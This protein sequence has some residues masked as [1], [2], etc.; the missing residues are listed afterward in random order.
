MKRVKSFWRKDT[1]SNLKVGNG[2]EKRVFGIPLNPR[3]P[4]IPDIVKS[5]TTYIEEFAIQEAGLFRVSG[6]HQE[7]N[8]LK[9]AYDR[10]EKIDFSLISNPHAVSSVLKQYLR[11]LPEPLLAFN[12][13]EA[14]ITSY[15]ITDPEMRLA[16]IKNVIQDLPRHYYVVLDCLIAFLY[17]VSLYS[18]YNKM[19][20]SNLAICFAP[21]LLRSKSE[22]TEQLVSD[23]HKSTA[24]VKIII[25]QYSEIFEKDPIT[26]DS[27]QVQPLKQFISD[28]YLLPSKYHSIN[29]DK[30]IAEIFEEEI[31]LSEQLLQPQLHQKHHHTHHDRPSVFQI[32]SNTPSPTSP[33]S[34]NSST[35]SHNLPDLSSPD[36]HLSSPQQ[37]SNHNHLD[38]LDDLSLDPHQ[39]NTHEH[40]DIDNDEEEDEELFKC[41]SISI[42]TEQARNGQLT[43][44]EGLN[45]SAQ[46]EISNSN[47]SI[48]SSGGTS[49]NKRKSASGNDV[50]IQG[51]KK[52]IDSTINR[53]R[54]EFVQI[55]NDVESEAVSF[56]E[57]LL[58]A[59]TMKNIMNI[60]IEGPDVDQKVVSSFEIPLDQT[61]T[62]G[63][64]QA[65]RL[66]T[67][68][69]AVVTRVT[70]SIPHLLQEISD[71]GDNII[72][73]PD[74]EREICLIDL[75]TIM[76]TLRAVSD[77][78][79]FFYNKWNQ[80]SPTSSPMISSP[81]P[82]S[83]PV[84]PTTITTNLSPSQN[85]SN[86]TSTQ[87]LP[88]QSPL[89]IS[90]SIS[91]SSSTSSNTTSTPI[92]ILVSHPSKSNL[93][94][95]LS[96]P[97]SFSNSS[98]L[99][100]ISSNTNNIGKS[101][102]S[103]S[104]STAASSSL[105]MS[106]KV[107]SE[108]D[109]IQR[110]VTIDEILIES[111]ES[112][113][114]VNSKSEL[115]FLAKVITNV[116]KIIH[117]PLE[118]A[119]TF[120]DIPSPKI[121][122]LKST[123]KQKLAPLISVVYVLIK[124]IRDL[125]QISKMEFESTTASKLPQKVIQLHSQRFQDLFRLLS[126]LPAFQTYKQSQ[127]QRE[128]AVQR[129]CEFMKESIQTTL[130][131]LKPLFKQQKQMVN[132]PVFAS[133]TAKLDQLLKLTRNITRIKKLFEDPQVVQLT[134]INF[135]SI[136]N[137]TNSPKS[138]SLSISS[139]LRTKTSQ[140]LTLNPQQP[141]PQPQQQQQQPQQQPQQQEI[142]EK[143]DTVKSL[144]SMLI[145]NVLAKMDYLDDIYFSVK[146]E[147][148]LFEII[149]L[150]KN[151]ILIFKEIK[152]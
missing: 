49:P 57:I 30:E 129:N 67:L 39:G 121:N 80:I 130:S 132:E 26:G 21:N 82:P 117:L 22:T 55:A 33:L 149:N 116:Q 139:F 1:K 63:S 101:T 54:E 4:Q 90:K 109:I 131:K 42:T 93:T 120:D 128:L 18:E 15:G 125:V 27:I 59:S 79:S 25:D 74:I 143:I 152:Q 61:S 124:E 23:S 20:S 78:L 44:N 111:E 119:A 92:P 64:D 137:L 53:L 88:S 11:E 127:S 99:S 5:T 86:N 97:N 43:P 2:S 114:Q 14:L 66:E 89:S 71:E 24:I 48:T 17:R 52:L 69:K 134:G 41:K 28:D 12:N 147:T 32:F 135:Q 106:F 115:I 87:P 60:L 75:I 8:L 77:L 47:N 70:D 95:S 102:S 112:L 98:N 58:I 150:L 110:L 45:V 146:L 29:L 7:I 104:S 34:L 65:K 46:L 31:E 83:S 123:P 38:D 140:F 13:Y 141:Q 9:N 148:Q 68:K 122:T 36:L 35:S 100:S 85:T 126:K 133:D 19:D 118:S 144:G 107:T 6:H 50:K 108:H 10:A 62:S 145:D 56:Q 105:F 3:T 113:M 136:D 51:I 72:E 40:I 142:L 138:S 96:L 91:I 37:A 151:V 103:S 81:K 84:P 94:Q 73:S 16:C 76:R